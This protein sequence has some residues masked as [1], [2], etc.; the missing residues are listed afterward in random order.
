LRQQSQYL[1]SGTIE[2][3]KWKQRATISPD[4]R[5]LVG[6]ET[7]VMMDVGG[8]KEKGIANSC[9]LKEVAIPCMV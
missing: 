1:E 5:N 2:R 9:S 6:I 3:P 7:T 8:V 4:R